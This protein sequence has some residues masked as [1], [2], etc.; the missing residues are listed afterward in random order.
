MKRLLIVAAAL[1]LGCSAASA[2]SKGDIYLGGMT[3]V[4]IQAGDG[5]VGAGFT[6]QPEFGGFV[7]DRCKL[8]IS[9]GYAVSGGIHSLTACP[10]FSYYVRLCDNVYYTPGIEA[11]FAMAIS[12]GAHPG[13]GV[14]LHLFSMEFRPTKHFG[15]TA[16]LAS[17]NFVALANAG[18]ALNFDL[19]LNPT[20][21]VKYYF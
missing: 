6:I 4:A 19:G 13:L 17:L 21:G 9:I 20:F 15:F 5:G 18:S 2:Q 11:G 10:N 8:G 7:A 3:G 16:N 12:G 14:G 1:L